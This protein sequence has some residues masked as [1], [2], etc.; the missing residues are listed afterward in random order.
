[1]E[2]QIPIL[3]N[4]NE[5]GGERGVWDQEEVNGNWRVSIKKGYYDIK[6]KF[7]KPLKANGKMYLETNTL[8]KQILNKKE[9]TDMIEMKNVYFSDIDCDLKP[10]YAIDSKY[11]FPFWVE[12]K[13][14]D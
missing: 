1:M 5:A 11:I 7:I 8:V 3:L 12:M 6:F 13:K 9:D 14:R 4:R 2:K 10:F